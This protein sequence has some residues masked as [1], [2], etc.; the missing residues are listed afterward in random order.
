VPGVVDGARGGRGPVAGLIMPLDGVTLTA[1]VSTFAPRHGHRSTREATD[2]RLAGLGDGTSVARP[3]T[4]LHE[5]RIWGALAL[6]RSPAATLGLAGT[7]EG[8]DHGPGP[9]RRRHPGARQ[10][11]RSA[12]VLGL[13]TVLP[14][15]GIQAALLNAVTNAAG[16]HPH[17]QGD[18]RQHRKG[19]RKG[20]KR[21]NA[22][23]EPRLPAAESPACRSDCPRCQT[24]N[25]AT[26]LCEPVDDTTPCDDGDPCTQPD[27]CRNGECISGDQLEVDLETDPN[28]CGQC[29][30]ICTGAGEICRNSACSCPPDWVVCV[31]V[32]CVEPDNCPDLRRFDRT[33]CQCECLRRMIR[34]YGSCCIPGQEVCHEQH[35][36]ETCLLD[37]SC[38]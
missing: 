14:L 22:T 33:T 38:R 3:H 26:G 13:L 10:P 36:I 18:H 21:G 19:K 16:R 28:N 31:G 27:T 25:P 30:N 37:G 20:K 12:G 34:C 2:V 9:L 6:C 35:C 15:A 4:R 23:K 8:G 17:R 24:C 1:G 32:G 29:G 5:A 11:G 7:G